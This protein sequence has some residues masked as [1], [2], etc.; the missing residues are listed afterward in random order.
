M[1]KNVV[2]AFGYVL[3]RTTRHFWQVLQTWLLYAYVLGWSVCPSDL[4]TTGKCFS[5]TNWTNTLEQSTSLNIFKRYSTVAYDRQNLS[6]LSIESIS[7]PEPVEINPSDLRRVYSF[8]LS[9]GSNATSD[10]T[11]VTNAL[12]FQIGWVLRLS[13]DDFPDDKDSPLNFLRGFL[14]IPIQFS[15][16][17]WQLVNATVYASDPE[18]TLYALPP[19]LD[20]TA[21]A[22]QVTYRTL[23]TKPWVV[24]VFMAAVV[25]MLLWNYSLFAYMFWQNTIVP[26]RS[27]FSEIDVSAKATYPPNGVE[28]PRPVSDYSSAL[29]DA[30]LGNARSST[31]V[32]A[33]NEKIIRVIETDGGRPGDKLFLLV[34]VN[35]EYLSELNGFSGLTTGVKY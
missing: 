28:V 11:E 10:D 34:V 33:L 1:D 6:I 2:K 29:R 23:S 4:Y 12:L 8:I 9:P 17:A 3:R 31:I 21:S 7:D 22:A 27:A 35:T 15:T 16:A 32:K 26:N 30:G 5:D 25:I 13:Q 20:T 24:H 18:S 19:D 14:T